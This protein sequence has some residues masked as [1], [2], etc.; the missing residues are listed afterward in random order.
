MLKIDGNVIR[1]N[2]IVKNLVQF[3]SG[4]AIA[5]IIFINTIGHIVNLTI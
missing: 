4:Y 5:D 3:I 1:L 2:D